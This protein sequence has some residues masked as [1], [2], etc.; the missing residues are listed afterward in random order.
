MRCSTRLL[1]AAS[2]ASARLVE[3][4]ICLA[5][6]ASFGLSRGTWKACG[7]RTASDV[8]HWTVTMRKKKQG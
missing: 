5:L 4:N 3:L 6:Q 1:L 7:L 2:I 8:N